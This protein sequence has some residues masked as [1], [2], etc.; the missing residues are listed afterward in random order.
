MSTITRTATAA[1][2]LAGLAACHEPGHITGTSGSVSQQPATSQQRFT[3]DP[4]EFGP[5]ARLLDQPGEYAVSCHDD[6]TV[7]NYWPDTHTAWR[8]AVESCHQ[9]ND[10]TQ[11]VTD[12]LNRRDPAAGWH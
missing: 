6:G 8:H 9:L 5:D 2:L 12:E 11:R 7:A 10:Y 1:V 4:A 3:P